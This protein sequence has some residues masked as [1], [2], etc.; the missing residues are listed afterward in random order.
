MACAPRMEVV[1]RSKLL[2][3]HVPVTVEIKTPASRREEA[4]RVGDGAYDLARRLEAQISE[5]NPNSEI[6]C[7][8]REAGKTYCVIGPATFDLLR[9][10]QELQQKTGGAFDLRFASVSPEG[11]GG[12]LDL[13]PQRGR[14]RL[15]HPETRIGVGAIGKGFI[16][17]AMGEYLQEKGFGDY[18]ISAGGDLRAS[19]SSWRV[20]VQ[21]PGAKP[22]EFVHEENIRNC[23]MATSGT[24]EQGNH[25][26]DPHNG[27]PVVDNKSVTVWAD[28]L[29]EADALATAL[30]VL[31]EKHTPAVLKNFAN[32]RVQ[33]TSPDGTYRVYP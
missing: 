33:W 2:M 32:I 20:G 4:W 23:A 14:A 16:V 5:Y 27:K 21:I 29:A 28:R 26:V 25:I 6:S 15:R 11:R 30:F 31:G 17:D 10:G 22:G 24:Y 3:G 8:N 19:G 7:L 18:L 13:D 12:S 1:V 9:Q